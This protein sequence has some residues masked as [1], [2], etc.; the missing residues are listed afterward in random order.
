MVARKFWRDELSK[1]SW[2]NN[3]RAC[4]FTVSVS[5]PTRDY[6]LTVF[7]RPVRWELAIRPRVILI[8]CSSMSSGS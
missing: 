8:C 7:D 1:Q 5:R 3:Y 4:E 6:F 2:L